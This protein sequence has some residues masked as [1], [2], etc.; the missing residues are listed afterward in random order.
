LRFGNKPSGAFNQSGSTL[1]NSIPGNT[2]THGPK[3]FSGF[4]GRGSSTG[5]YSYAF[6]NCLLASYHQYETIVVILEQR[7]IKVLNPST[8]NT[9]TSSYTVA[10]VDIPTKTLA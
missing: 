7:I 10:G 2:R 4:S 9:Q 1:S 8:T 5:S 6:L 3:G